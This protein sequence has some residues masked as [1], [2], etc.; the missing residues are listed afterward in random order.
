VLL[1]FL[2]FFRRKETVDGKYAIHL[3][4]DS[5]QQTLDVTQKIWRM[6]LLSKLLSYFPKSIFIEIIEEIHYLRLLTG[7][8][9][10]EPSPRSAS[11]HPSSGRGNRNRSSSVEGNEPSDNLDDFRILIGQDQYKMESEI[12]KWM[13]I[14]RV[15]ESSDLEVNTFS[16]VSS[17]PLYP[18]SFL[19]SL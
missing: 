5:F 15:K 11:H 14:E 1:F 17:C 18:S 10:L 2:I 9:L 13:P 3:V 12:L 19:S 7:L 6:K 4:L 16:C 8:D